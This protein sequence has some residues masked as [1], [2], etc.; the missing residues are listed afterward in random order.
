MGLFLAETDGRF[1]RTLAW[2]LYFLHDGSFGARRR[3]R[4]TPSHHPWASLSVTSVGPG[5]RT[6]TRRKRR[7]PSSEGCGN[8]PSLPGFRRI[9]NRGTP[10]DTLISGTH[11]GK[12]DVSD[13]TAGA[14]RYERLTGDLRSPAGRSQKAQEAIGRLTALLKSGRLSFRDQITARQL[15][16]ELTESLK[17]K[18]RR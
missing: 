16:Q 18:P 6:T 12:H 3:R 15:I 17:T 14:V 7:F 2:R 10:S 8:V 13:G 5:G 4:V 1:P 11:V 9:S